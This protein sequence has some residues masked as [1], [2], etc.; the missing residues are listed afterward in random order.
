M[1][2]DD[3]RNCSLRL[4]LIAALVAAPLVLTPSRASADDATPPQPRVE[5][6]EKWPRFRLSEYAG[7]VVFG[8]A[9]WTIT[10]YRLPP[11]Q[12]RWQGGVLFDDAFR[13]WLRAET[14][15][16][17][18]RAN[19]VSD[20]V[21]LGGSAVP[22]VIDLPIVLLAHRQPQV[23]WQILMMD[24]EAYAVAGFI[25]RT[26]HLELGRGRPSV[27]DC[28]ADP[29]Y[30]PLCGGRGNNA[31]FPSGH[32]LGVATAAGLTCVHHRYLP[33]YGH[34]V[35]DGSVCG[36][37]ALATLVTGATRIMADRHHSTDVLAGA[38]IGFASG[39]GI[40]W[41]LHYRSR[42]E[43]DQD[44]ALRQRPVLVPFAG[45]TEIGVGLV[46]TI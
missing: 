29:G 5:W 10:R 31:S 43:S 21:W 3:R 33:L 8:A 44:H 15:E 22:F 18:A 25:G 6:S 12:P 1:F 11:A 41:L 30:D 39:Y 35:A 34:P 13:G 9:T 26:M 45:T 7:T 40:P 23:A 19:H 17:R 36:V 42:G 20:M 27:A 38:A 16:G 37:M 32:T 2:H 14:P 46:G 28:A 24:L 4:A